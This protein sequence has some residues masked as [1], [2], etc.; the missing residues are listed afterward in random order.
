MA[1]IEDVERVITQFIEEGYTYAIARQGSLQ[2][3]SEDNTF[4]LAEL[5]PVMQKDSNEIAED[6]S[7]ISLPTAFDGDPLSPPQIGKLAKATSFKGQLGHI[8][9]A[10]QMTGSDLKS[11][12]KIIDRDNNQN[13]LTFEFLSRWFIRN[14]RWALESKAELQRVQAI[15]EGQVTITPMDGQPYD[16]PLQQTGQRVTVPSGTN[17]APAGW[18][19]PDFDPLLQTIVPLINEM[20][21]RG[22]TSWRTYTSTRIAGV[23]SQNP[24]MTTTTGTI[25]L[26]TANA[27]L[28]TAQGPVSFDL[29]NAKL[30]AN[31]VPP[32]AKYN[33]VYPTLNGNRRYF[34][35]DKFVIIGQTG[36][37]RDVDLGTG[38]AADELQ[39]ETFKN[40]LGYYGEGTSI[41]QT[42]PGAVIT[43]K[44]KDLKPIGVYVEGYREGFPVLLAD[45]AVIVITIPPLG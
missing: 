3:G 44:V 2:F 39:L 32:I 45:E 11:L 41:G 36:D 5:L 18:Y 25:V 40:T 15:V 20:E 42:N 19:S 10:V 21:N 27:T 22:Y 35:D 26:N 7:K 29:L 37:E 33:R 31:G 1:T 4:P 16:V 38:D 12:M 17:A 30:Q 43:P 24:N 8:D 9:I 28:K 6:V 14:V 34:P 13:E 23:L